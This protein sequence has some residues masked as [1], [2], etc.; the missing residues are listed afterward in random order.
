MTTRRRRQ[1]TTREEV[2]NTLLAQLLRQHGLDAKA[3][4]RSRE[5]A[6][7]V[8]IELR[9]GELV[10]LECKWESTAAQLDEQLDERLAQFPEAVAVVSV[11][12]PERLR[13]EEDVQAALEAETGLRWRIHGSRGAAAPDSPERSGSVM[14]LADQ[15][16]ALP[17]ELEG[18]DVVAAAA[19]VI[20]YALEKSVAPLRQHDRISERIAEIIAEADKESDR[21]A[22]LQIGCLVLFNA[23]AFQD[24]LAES[25]PSVPT[26]RE[27]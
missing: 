26:A 5:G 6:P 7:D 22:A 8:R 11:I 27:S 20:G 16:R 13:V 9:G 3:E 17:L 14:A 23:L 1:G 21:L 12:H 15:L 25:N 2:V 19:A 10:L 24:R 4:R 18:A